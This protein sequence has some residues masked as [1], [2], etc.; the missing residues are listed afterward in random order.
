M[1]GPERC[2][3]R[4][5]DRKKAR[6]NNKR[7]FPC[8][9]DDDGAWEAVCRLSRLFYFC[10]WK[11]KIKTNTVQT[12]PERRQK[13]PP[14]G[15]IPGGKNSPV[16]GRAFASGGSLTRGAVPRRGRTLPSTANTAIPRLAS[17]GGRD[18]SLVWKLCMCRCRGAFGVH[19]CMS[20]GEMGFYAEC[21]RR[22]PEMPNMTSTA[23]Y[24]KHFIP[25]ALPEFHLHA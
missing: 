14:Q 1:I 16:R 18:E 7:W 10:N 2:G 13:E 21:R 8:P 12:R 11:S 6:R 22:H 15:F 4:A 3:G 25:R 19:E 5:R 24:I 23:D 20:A 17:L 9:L